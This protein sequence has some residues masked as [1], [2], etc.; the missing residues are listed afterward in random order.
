MATSWIPIPVTRSTTCSRPSGPGSG[1]SRPPR[2]WTSPADALLD[3]QVRWEHRRWVVGPEGRQSVD[4]D[5]ADREI[6]EPL[7]V[8]G[9]HVPRGVLGRAAANGVGVGGHVVVPA[10][11]LR[12]ISDLELP[13]LRW[14]VV[15]RLEPGSLFVLADVQEELDHRGP[16]VGEQPL[17]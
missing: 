15:S 10:L 11:A 2:S 7:V 9:N 16:G 13:V 3:R 14:I 1:G 6:P 5:C 8:R 12:E 17:E 4:E